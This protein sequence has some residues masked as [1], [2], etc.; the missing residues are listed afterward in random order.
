MVHVLATCSSSQS[1]KGG[2]DVEMAS[3]ASVQ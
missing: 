1:A 3:A 2:G